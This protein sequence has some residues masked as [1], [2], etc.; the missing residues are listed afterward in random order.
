M[1]HR[2]AA[3]VTEGVRTRAGRVV[4]GCDPPCGCWELNPG[5]EQEQGLF[6]QGILHLLPVALNLPNA[7]TL[8]YSSSCCADSQ[9]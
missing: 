5:P 1:C 4:D 7:T 3:E 2:A 6:T 9:P 8:Y